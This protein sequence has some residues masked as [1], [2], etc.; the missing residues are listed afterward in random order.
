MPAFYI[1]DIAIR[2]LATKADEKMKDSIL[3]QQFPEIGNL[4][5]GILYLDNSGDSFSTDISLNG[6]LSD[7]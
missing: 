2:I 4:M 1:Q 3:V 7:V 5:Q 6:D